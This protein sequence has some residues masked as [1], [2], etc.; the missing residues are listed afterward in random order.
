MA[1]GM[2]RVCPAMLAAKMMVAPNSPK[3]R[4]KLN[5]EPTSRPGAARRKVTVRKVRT[6]PAPR[7]RATRSRRGVHALNPEAHRAQHQGKADHGRG[8][9]RALP[10][11][12]QLEIEGCEHRAEETA[13]AK[14]QQEQIAGD[15]R[16]QDQRQVTEA[17]ERD[18]ERK[19]PPGQQPAQQHGWQQAQQHAAKCYA[20][21]EQ[22][23]LHFLSAEHV[24]RPKR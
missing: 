3:E 12:G 2:V 21:R 1:E 5:S 8:Q 22:Q 19:L 11:E 15:H 6:G 20:Q 13:A 7:V 14:K 17:V 10:V 23:D 9:D 18:L 16:R 4:A 24:G